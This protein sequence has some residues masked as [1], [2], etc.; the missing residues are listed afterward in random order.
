MYRCLPRQWFT[1]LLALSV[2]GKI[3]YELLNVACC[4][5][6]KPQMPYSRINPIPKLLHTFVRCVAKIRFC[7]LLEPLLCEILELNIRRNLS[8]K[9]FFLK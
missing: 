6:I 1:C 5:L 3:V 7:I 8:F 9:A 4:D 2:K